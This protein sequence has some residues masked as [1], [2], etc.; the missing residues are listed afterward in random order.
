MQPSVLRA[1]A[2]G[3]ALALASVA[4]ATAQ[5][6][7]RNQSGPVVYQAETGPYR[8]VRFVEGL[9]NPWSMAFLPGGDMLVTELAGRLRLVRGGVLQPEPIAGVPAVRFMG[10]GGL[11]EVALHPRFEENQLVYLSYSKPNEDGSAGTT[12]VARGRFEGNR[13]HDVSDVFVADAW[14]PAGGHYGSRLAFDADGYLFV[15]IGDRQNFPD[16]ASLE[17]HPAQD[18][19]NHAGTI[20]RLHDDGRVPSDN[21]FVGHP[22]ARPEIWSYGHRSPQGLV[23]DHA[24][25]RVWEVEHGPQGGDELNLILP[26]R[27]YGWPVVGYGVQYGGPRIHDARHREGME[28]P[29]Q[30]WTPS[31]ATSGLMLYTGDRFPDWQGSL[32]VG[33]LAGQQIA[34]LPLV[35]GEAGVQVG[36]LERPPLMMGYGR[37]RD[38]RQG[39]DGYIYV[40]IDGRFAGGAATPIVRLEPVEDS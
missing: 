33:G 32:F 24:T 6:L 30:F 16:P 3:C 22:D 21:P 26:G 38:I 23:I 19:R 1:A 34:R 35:E 8:V 18:L 13:L 36:R 29:V 9:Q 28:Q 7:F 15:T 40:A 2:L 12:A 17:Q 39:P 5:E 10:Q 20:V 14:G 11:M 31:I 4:P 25:G 27:N 37:V